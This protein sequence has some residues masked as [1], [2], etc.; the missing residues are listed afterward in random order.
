M[1]GSRL[2][3][4]DKAA[5]TEVRVTLGPEDNRV[6]RQFLRR[7]QIPSGITNIKS[8]GRSG[9]FV[10]GQK[11]PCQCDWRDSVRFCRDGQSNFP[12]QADVPGWIVAKGSDKPRSMSLIVVPVSPIRTQDNRFQLLQ[13]FPRRSKFGLFTPG[14]RRA[15][16][17]SACHP[18]TSLL[19]G[20]HSS[21]VFAG[22]SD[23]PALAIWSAQTGQ[24]GPFAFPQTEFWPSDACVTPLSPREALRH[25]AQGRVLLEKGKGTT[26]PTIDGPLRCVPHRDVIRP[27]KK[28]RP[29]AIQI[30]LLSI[31][32]SIFRR[33]GVI[34]GVC[35]K[36]SADFVGVG[37]LGA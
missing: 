8:D 17:D 21:E 14:Y 28:H 6:S 9:K 26:D 20:E 30:L 37:V 22:Q 24:F 1:T 7:L 11:Q 5:S 27:L 19:F 4:R 34:V 25:T 3:G 29:E 2:I 12:P 23:G 33:G 18:V 31:L 10:R 16:Q 32:K 35:R 36:C 13:K 15:R